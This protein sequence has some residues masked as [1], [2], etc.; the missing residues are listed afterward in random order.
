MEQFKKKVAWRIRGLQVGILFFMILN[1]LTIYISRQLEMNTFTEG[2]LAGFQSGLSIG[3][4]MVL[5]VVLFKLRRA[6]ANEEALKRLYYK[7]NDERMKL[8]R[9]K[10]GMPFLMISS[11]LM[12]F[13]G[14]IAGYFNITVFYTL[15]LAATVQMGIGAAAKLYFMKTM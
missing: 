4:L 9:T 15:I 11:L 2:H 12:I 1:G 3:L 10:A 6:S 5:V 14:T 7:E 13:A 8:I